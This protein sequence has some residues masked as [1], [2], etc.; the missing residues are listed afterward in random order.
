[1]TILYLCTANICRSPFAEFYARML[2]NKLGDRQTS[3]ESAGTHAP[4]G[5]PAD[6]VMVRLGQRFGIELKTHESKPIDKA[7]L[8][9]AERII[10]MER[11]HAAYVREHYPTHARKLETLVEDGGNLADP[12]GEGVKDYQRTIE[13]L[14]AQVERHMMQIRYPG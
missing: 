14:T 5:R 2:A 13:L 12:T 6:P 9:R 1:M 10:V 7:M 3:F 8:E 11:A 4:T